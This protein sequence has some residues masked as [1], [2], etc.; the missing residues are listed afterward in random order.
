MLV[1][2]SARIRSG[3]LPNHPVRGD[4]RPSGEPHTEWTTL[5]SGAHREQENEWDVRS[6]GQHERE[7]AS[8]VGTDGTLSANPVSIVK[9]E[10]GDRLWLKAS[11]TNWARSII[12]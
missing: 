2:R 8:Q 11:W 5:N 3:R 10:N 4:D 1:P 12:W 6:R 9:R 7:H